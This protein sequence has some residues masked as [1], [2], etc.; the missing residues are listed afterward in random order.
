M[1]PA[2]YNGQQ[3][4][5]PILGM[6]NNR[7]MVIVTTLYVSISAFFG[8]PSLKLDP[9]I[10]NIITIA[11]LPALCRAATMLPL[12]TAPLPTNTSLF[13]QGIRASGIAII[14]AITGIFTYFFSSVLNFSHLDTYFFSKC[15]T[16]SSST[17]FGTDAFASSSL[18]SSSIG[19]D[20]CER[21]SSS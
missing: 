8:N 16:M 21:R 15:L 14:A 10:T 9:R 6:R 5:I 18:S 1:T 12:K 4:A 11:Q 17:G 20:A 2:L 19:V 7:A 3:I 13:T